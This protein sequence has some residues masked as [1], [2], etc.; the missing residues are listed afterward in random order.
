M[1][2]TSIKLL[3]K[4]TGQHHY[5]GSDYTCYFRVT[6]DNLQ[7]G[8]TQIL[9]NFPVGFPYHW[10]QTRNF[11]KYLEALAPGIAP[12]FHTWPWPDEKCNGGNW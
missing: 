12:P 5:D 11:G 6:T 9:A 1:A 7:T 4:A 8:V 10:Y 2:V 3:R